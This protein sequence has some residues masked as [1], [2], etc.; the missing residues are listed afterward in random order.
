MGNDSDQVCTITQ[1]DA[2]M[3]G[4]CK[5]DQGQE[6]QLD[7]KVDGKDVVWS[8]K[9]QYEGSPLTISYH[10]TLDGD[11]VSGTLAVDPF[12]VTGDF[13]ATKSK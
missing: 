4:T 9:G 11:K 3:T 12:G 1:K 6:Q 2:A 7:G 5:N 13:K 8:V 10:G